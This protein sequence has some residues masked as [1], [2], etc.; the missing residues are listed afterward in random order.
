M[1]RVWKVVSLCE[2]R[3]TGLQA[4]VCTMWTS[5][6]RSLCGHDRCFS[7]S[8]GN[9]LHP[10]RP[11]LHRPQGFTQAVNN[12]RSRLRRC[13]FVMAA[14]T[15][16]TPPHTHT[17]THLQGF[18]NL[19]HCCPLRAEGFPALTWPFPSVG[20]RNQTRL[21]SYLLNLWG[22]ERVKH[23]QTENWLNRK[24]NRLVLIGW[25][26]FVHCWK[27]KQKFPAESAEIL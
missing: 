5:Q 7:V 1:G 8:P 6:P 14:I 24:G 17:H 18:W 26:C 3:H 25:L 21:L 11:A 23:T 19:A 4:S 13:S 20:Y 9:E 27:V 22:S 16:L 15:P 10:C 12:H 2:K